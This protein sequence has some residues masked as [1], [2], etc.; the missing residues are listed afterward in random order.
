MRELLPIV[1]VFDGSGSS[2]CRTRHRKK[3]GQPMNDLFTTDHPTLRAFQAFHESLDQEKSFD[4]D[5]LRN[6]AYLAEEIGEVVSA[7]RDFKKAEDPAALEATKNHLGEELADCLAY[8]L[9]LANY[10]NIDLQDAYVKKMK[11]NL[12]RTWPKQPNSG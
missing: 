10:S 6:V 5:M 4:V 11:R 1:E 3:A 2:K 9:K 12:G 8:I 7:I